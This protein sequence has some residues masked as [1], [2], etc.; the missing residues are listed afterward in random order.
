MALYLDENDY[1]QNYDWMPEDVK[2][3]ILAQ[4]NDLNDYG[5]SCYRLMN[6][7]MFKQEDRDFF[8]EQMSKNT[9]ELYQI[10]DFLHGCGIMVEN[11]WRC[12][13]DYFLATYDDAVDEI[14]YLHEL[15]VDGYYNE[16]NE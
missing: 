8:R 14:D 10:V 9:R 7:R 1:P 4:L 15:M 13:R 2:V 6:N 11:G 3:K 16:D 5:R 12:N